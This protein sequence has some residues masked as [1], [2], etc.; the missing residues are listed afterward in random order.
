MSWVI[1]VENLVKEFEDFR[2]E[3]P[4]LEI[5]EGEVLGVLGESGA[6]KSV[7]IH[8]L[9]GLDDYEPDEGSILYRVGLCPEC[10][11]VERPEFIGE[12]C[13]KCEEGELEE[14]V[15]DLWGL[16]D[17]ER[18]R[19]RKRIAIM[20]QRTFALY[21]EQTV[22]ENV[23]EALEEAGYS[24]EEAVQR[25]VDLIEMVQLEHRITHLARDLSGGEKQR[26]VLIRQLAKKPI[27]FLADE[28]TGTLDPETAD[29]VHRALREGVKEEGVTMVI[30]SHWPE[31]IE[32]ISDKVMWLEDGCVKE[33][34][35]PS[36]VV[37]K[38]L[39]LVEEVEREEAEVGEDIIRAKDVKKY[40]YSIERG[41]VK[42]VDGVSLDVKEAEI[43]GI[44]GKSG[45]G[46]TTLA[47]IL[48]GVL[49]PTEGEVYVRVG[50]DW[51]DMT[52]R[53]ERGRAKRYIGMLH[54]QY[55]LYPHRTVLEN[56]TKAIGIELPDELARMKAVHVLKVVG[57]DEERAA[58]ILD[59]Y[60]DQLSEGERHRVALAQVLIREPR[61]LI[62]DEPTGTMDPIT[63]RKV[64]KSILNARK[65]MNQTFV[66]VSHDMDFVL[67]VCDRASLMRDGKF[68]KTGDPEEIVRELTPEERE[69]MIR[70]E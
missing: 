23:M 6:G 42:A 19:F 53:R 12:P 55:T 1:R 28:P 59:K 29:I 54:Q 31:V 33:V 41:V 36:E 20:F 57:F 9:K 10:E 24:G 30:T 37:S 49:E 22:L 65:E 64:A 66:I 17:T 68:V 2:L 50:D 35:E 8:A 63:M 32:D 18:R 4:E 34:G 3:I 69:E 48:A 7:F 27:V 5:E 52:D 51:V 70:Q 46:K 60:P 13:P 44:V 16:S 56:L 61:I 25:A 40:Y 67:M 11:W 26:V 21:E 58:N 45:A 14:E 43:Y 15:V 39:E 62:L 47:K 38:Y